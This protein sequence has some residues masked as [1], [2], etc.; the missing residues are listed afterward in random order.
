M[1]Y[2]FFR[3]DFQGL[4]PKGN[5]IYSADKATVL[6]KPKGVNQVARVCYLDDSDTLILG[7]EGSDMR[8]ISRVFF[9]QGYLAGNRETVSFVPGAGK[10]AA[11]VT[12]AVKSRPKIT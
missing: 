7:E 12:A 6:D 8:H 1:A 3:Y 4:D 9:C 5:P 11:C 10:E 2:G